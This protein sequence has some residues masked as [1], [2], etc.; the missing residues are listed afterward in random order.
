M[1]KTQNKNLL[2]YISNMKKL[3]NNYKEYKDGIEILINKFESEFN[4]SEELKALKTQYK[5]I[6]ENSI[7]LGNFNEAMLMIKEYE[8][9]FSQDADLLNMKGIIAMHNGE[10]EEAELLFKEST[11]LEVN[12]NTM[13]NIAYLKECIGDIAEARSFYKKIIYNCEDKDIMFDSQQ[14]LKF[15]NR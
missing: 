3:L 7:Q 14:R 9:I 4:E 15:L 6:V 10:F 2:E 8:T 5:S 1:L 13:F 11:N 12:Y